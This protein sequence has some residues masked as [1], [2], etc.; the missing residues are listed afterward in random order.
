MMQWWKR[1]AVAVVMAMAISVAPRNVHAS[2]EAVS[3]RSAPSTADKAAQESPF[4]AQSSVLRMVGG[5]FLCLGM[6]GC[7]IHVYRR[8][9]LP[10]TG[11]TQRRLQLVERLQLSQKSA[12]VLVKLDGK[13]FIMSTGAESSRLVPLTSA[14]E[15]LFDEALN[16]ACQDVGE[17]N[18]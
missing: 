13:E 3:T 5:L 15:E 6:F 2:D 12:L 18:A 1:V 8:Y 4:N 17:Y 16:G 7:G 14:N 11:S 9:V 10:R